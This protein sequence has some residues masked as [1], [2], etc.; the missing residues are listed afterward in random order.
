MRKLIYTFLIVI[1]ILG[2]TAC[3]AAKEDISFSENILVSINH[4]APGF[5]TIEECVDA[6]IFVRKDKTVS[7]VVYY[8][9]ELEIASFSIAEEEYETIA[10]MTSP[11][12][13]DRL[14]VKENRDV[15]DGSSYHIRL[16][17]ENDE[18]LI[19]KGGYMPE[20]KKFWEIYNG[21]KAVLEPYE[22]TKYV[23]D[24]REHLAS[25]EPYLGNLTEKEQAAKEAYL[26]VADFLKGD[27]LCESESA[28][29]R[30]YPADEMSDI[31][32]IDIQ[33]DDL[34]HPY[35][36]DLY[37]SPLYELKNE[38]P[39]WS[40]FGDVEV[41]SDVEIPVFFTASLGEMSFDGMLIAAKD[42]SYL[43]YRLV[44]GEETWYRF[45]PYEGECPIASYIYATS[46]GQM[47]KNMMGT[48]QAKDENVKKAALLLF[49]MNV[50]YLYEDHFTVSETNGVYTIEALACVLRYSGGYHTQSDQTA[51]FYLD[52]EGN[53]LY[54][55]IWRITEE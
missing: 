12:Q 50:A 47:I 13:I 52:E 39:V 25:D 7:V 5:G 16:Y 45:T 40:T 34:F 6:E 51:V 31:Y 1:A 17:D 37:N 9:E 3:G 8:P 24:Y 29:I 36:Y 42:G 18:K 22:I 10:Q 28:C 33:A 19:A 20:G 55:S 43:K 26:E 15:C 4:G 53:P 30:I 44:E 2:V 38:I 27:W 48:A 21:I 11:K 54:E 41:D 35:A 14:K 32:N 46:I 23:V 49:D